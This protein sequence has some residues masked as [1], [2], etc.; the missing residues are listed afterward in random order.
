MT[1]TPAARLKARLNGRADALHDGSD[2]APV[3]GAF[4][5]LP[6]PAIVEILGAAG[7]DFVIIDQ[8]H[9]PKS[10]ETVTDMIRAAEACGVVPLV[11]VER[12]EP[13]AILH[14]LEVGARGLVLPFVRQRAD[15]VAARAAMTYPPAGV[16]G[17][18]TQTRTAGYGI[19]RGGFAAYAQAAIDDLILVGLIE[20]PEGIAN[21]GDIA[22]LGDGYTGGLDAALIGRGDLAATMGKLGQTNH[23]AVDGAVR[24]A[25]A[26]V[27]AS[28]QGRVAAGMTVFGASEVA[29]WQAIGCR[30][31]VAAS[32]ASLILTAAQRWVSE[33]RGG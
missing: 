25:I 33:G 27:Q 13:L 30:L 19:H 7:F 24:G 22:A 29:P 32:E 26:A 23:P 14:A 1:T 20:D 18:C 2:S 28:G 21:A 15:V 12:N 10:W 9:S 17:L 16:R 5:F 3:L 11:R 4:L 6:S 8:E 31:A